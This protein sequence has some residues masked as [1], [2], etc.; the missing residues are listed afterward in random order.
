MH[1][2]F[3]ALIRSGTQELVSLSKAKEEISC[4]WLSRV[5]IKVDRTLEKYKE[6]MLAKGYL[7]TKGIDFFEIFSPI[8]K[9]TTLR[10]MIIVEFHK[11]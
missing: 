3:D 2:E 7:Q 11:G 8:V 9:L 6:K 1:E 5:K 4:K 10:V